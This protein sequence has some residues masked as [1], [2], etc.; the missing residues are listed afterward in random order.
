MKHRSVVLGL[1]VLLFGL[2]AAAKYESDAKATKPAQVEPLHLA[3][4]YQSFKQSG[5]PSVIVFSYDAD[6]CETTKRF[7]NEYNTK[8]RALLEKYR[9]RFNTLF[10][11]TGTLDEEQVSEFLAVAREAKITEVPCVLL[12][13]SSGQPVQVVSGPFDDNELNVAIERLLR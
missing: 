1:F 10:V 7:F 9:K 4:S 13:D 5:K 12:L 8:A 2:V 3:A 11:N 6:C